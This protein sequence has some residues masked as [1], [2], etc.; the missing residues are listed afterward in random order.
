MTAPIT[1]EIPPPIDVHRVIASL[2]D[3]APT[4]HANRIP[5][6][7]ELPASPPENFYARLAEVC[8]LA[9]VAELPVPLESGQASVHCLTATWLSRTRSYPYFQNDHLVIATADPLQE[10]AIFEKIAAAAAAPTFTLVVT[11]PQE[12]SRALQQAYYFYLAAI[13]EGWML[14]LYHRQSSRAYMTPIV[15]RVFPIALGFVYFAALALIPSI[16]LTWSFI[17]LTLLYLTS[18]IVKFVVTLAG[19][20]ADPL[21]RVKKG[22]LETL[23]P[24]DLP[25]Y[26]VLV[27]L[28]DEAKLVPTIVTNIAALAY[29][30]EKLDIKF[31]VEATD[32]PTL[33]ALEALGI[34]QVG[35]DL[36]PFDYTC[37]I[38]RVPPGSVSTKPRSCDYALNFARGSYVVIFDAEDRPE[39]DQLKKAVL[40]FLRA[41]LNTVCV[42]GKLTYFNADQNLLTRLFTL[43]YGF[44]FDF[45]LPGLQ[46][47]GSPVP[48]GG[49]SNH[50]SVTHLRRLGMWDPYNVT[51]DA[52]LGLRIFRQGKRTVVMDSYTFEEANSRFGNWIRQRTRWQKGFLLTFLVHTAHPLTLIHEIGWRKF[53]WTSIVFG[54]NFFFPVF[55]LVL[56]GITLLWLL[57]IWSI[58][59]HPL[60][61]SAALANLI[62]GNGFY[63]ITHLLPALKQKQYRMVPYALLLPLYWLLISVASAR[64]YIQFMSS[65]YNWEKT[66]HGLSG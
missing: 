64:A 21:L 54:G 23:L 3:G 28:K 42:Q 38:I 45:F 11:H 40:A 39:P 35:T 22:E 53:L 59:V 4:T 57:N 43:E 25:V 51:E 15:P 34:G 18:N 56:W 63:I 17:F 32:S 48:L 65:P 10:A 6:L 47:A 7:P 55:N 33:D 26:T 24:D 62:L 29:P 1:S 12:I 9:Y 46:I 2:E 66:R 52:D 50:F 5:A 49:T 13:T 61:H 36:T 16:T 44:W 19:R 8:G 37:E 31:V 27:P 20:R 41:P 14:A 58:A 60:I 30:R